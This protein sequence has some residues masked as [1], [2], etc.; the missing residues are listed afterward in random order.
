MAWTSFTKNGIPMKGKCEPIEG[1]E[2]LALC[3]V[4][5]GNNEA[6]AVIMKDPKSDRVV[7]KSQEHSIE[8]SDDPKMGEK[9]E[10]ALK[11][12]IKNYVSR[13]DTL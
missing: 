11:E 12:Y 2:G 13:T 10:A 3:T 8:N 1:Q 5:I 7:R 6:R 4:R 9:L